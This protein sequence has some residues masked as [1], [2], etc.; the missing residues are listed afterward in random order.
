[1]RV[2]LINSNRFK[3]P[4]PVLPF[5]L[6]CVAAAVEQAGHEVRVLDLCFSR[7]PARDV[8]ETIR[9]YRPDIVG[10]GIRNIDNCAG[11]RTQFLLDEIRR[12]A[13]EPCRKAFDGPIVL[14]GA[15]VGINAAEILEHFDMELAVRGDGEAAMVE[16]IRRLEANEPLDGMPGLVRRVGGRTVENNEPMRV[17]R[18]DD[19]PL[20]RVYDHLDTA[21]YRHYDSPLQIQTKRGCALRCSYCTYNR[22][23]GR[24]WRLRDP[25]R[26]AD[27]IERLVRQTGMA[28][29][30]FTDS[31]FNYPLDH[32]KAVLRAIIGRNLKLRLRTMGLNPG[33]VDDEL[34][35]LMVQAGFRDVDL[36]A[37]SCCDRTLKGLGK[38][39]RT[40]DVLRAARILRAHG[41][42][43]M[44]C[45]LLGGPDETE[46][47][48][49][50]TL[51][52]AI[53]AAGPW[54]LIDIGIG[55]RVYNGA[56][57]ADR[58][59][60]TRPESAV[61]N[62]LF[63][64]TY[65]GGALDVERLKALV[66]DRALRETNVFMY[67]E[68]AR[69]P[70]SFLKLGAWLFRLF[71]PNRPMWRWFILI[72]RTEKALGVLALKRAL[73][74]RKRLR[75]A[76]ALPKIVV[77]SPNERENDGIRKEPEECPVGAQDA[78][79]RKPGAPARANERKTRKPLLPGSLPQSS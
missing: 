69:T 17:S 33:A 74:R 57:I 75:E 52:T 73:Y 2:L 76:A 61:G 36:G 5:G 48:V 14:G 31:T 47:T 25:Q 38:N 71:A 32:S 56:P 78:F 42:A 65:E 35:G 43:V 18:I 6:G 46:E 79:S 66:K 26:I 9:N 23:E 72:R 55:L 60:S 20:D 64:T 63:P 62:F 1:M 3:Q 40:A 12:E 34:A 30:E 37:E 13:I 11:Y 24:S 59:R 8:A 45:L 54:D 7:R 4:W 16:L 44:W 29:I 27:D 77:S 58:V 53:G 39:F 50:E 51:D 49:R 70:A 28:H 22:I 21:A 19:L 15:A 67:D 10:I 41:I 68:D